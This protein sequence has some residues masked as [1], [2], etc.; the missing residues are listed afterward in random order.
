MLLASGAVTQGIEG[1]DQVLGASGD[2]GPK[3]EQDDVPLTEWIWQLPV[4]LREVIW[5]PARGVQ[6][7][8]RGEVTLRRGLQQQGRA[9]RSFSWG[10]EHRA[11]A[12]VVTREVPWKQD[13]GHGT[14]EEVGGSS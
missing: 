5:Y 7:G 2:R 1:V 11:Q 6:G 13:P 14:G 3:R 10:G 4:L 9:S 12:W 8:G